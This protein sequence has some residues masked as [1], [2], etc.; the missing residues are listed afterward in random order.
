MKKRSILSLLA[1]VLL[2]TALA[3]PTPHW[4]QQGSA[5]QLIVDNCP[6][7]I[8]GGE[9][10]NSSASSPYDIDRI[11]PKLK[12]TGLNTVLVPAYWDLIEAEEGT[13][14]FSLV[15]HAITQARANDL[16][17]VFLWFGAWKNSMSCYAPL[18]FKQ[19]YKKY[20]RVRTQTGKPLEI[21][22]PFSDNVFQADSK[23]FKAFMRHLSETDGDKHTV[24]MVQVENEIGM[25]ESARDYSEEANRLFQSAIPE[26]LAD[27]LVKN[28]KTLHPWLAEK[29]QKAGGKTEG[30]WQKVFGTDLYTD[31]IFM[32]WHY[33]TYVERMIQCGR[34]A[35][36]LPMYVNAAMNSRG[37]KP[38]EYP[39]AGPLAHLI[40][41][42]HCAAPG[43]DLLAPDLYDKG[44]TGWTAQYK[45]HNNPLFIP[46]IRLEPNDGVRAF[47]VFG[48]HDGIGFSP[49]SIE[50]APDRPSYQLTQS[51]LKLKEL[52]PLITRYQGQGAMKGLLF[53]QTEKERTLAWDNTLLICKHFFTLP[54]DSRATDGS[55]WP[56]G[57]GLVIR[58]AEDEYL[59]AGSGI[60]VEFKSKEEAALSTAQAKLGED[61]FV[62]EGEGRQASAVRWKNEKRIGIGSVDEV[63]VNE[64]GSLN[65]IRRYNGDQ[66]HQGRHARIGVDNFQIL[67]V[68]LY[69]YR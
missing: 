53:D 29:W 2:S 13:F 63:S 36:N 12:R 46:E 34:E 59:I 57:G 4:Q 54:W 39:S 56:E 16:R 52:M 58:M 37:R 14:D 25:L 21:A 47:Y 51:Y 1:G 5:K 65:F 43:I 10:G 62:L 22:S 32:A 69:E 33:A 19:D 44:F 24:I 41:I 66:D 40:D 30:N 8:L 67:H 17:I 60:V 38:G 23:A 6:Y 61:G 42:W 48:E 27:Y 64:D 50:D 3:Q 18:W 45:L 26:E 55:V 11:F 68:K 7:L 9:L 35:Y 20:P 28:K 49:F 15:D 31:E